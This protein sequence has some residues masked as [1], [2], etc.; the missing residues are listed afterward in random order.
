ML[1]RDVCTI[2]TLALRTVSVLLLH[3]VA[4]AARP[5]G[6]LHGAP[7]CRLG[8]PAG[9]A[10]ELADA[11][12]SPAHAVP[13]P[14]SRC[15]IHDRD[16]TS[17]IAMPRF[18]RDSIPSSR[19]RASRSFGPHTDTQRESDHTP[20]GRLVGTTFTP[21]P[22]P[23]GAMH[24]RAHVRGHGQHTARFLRSTCATRT[25]SRLTP[26]PDALNC[27]IAGSCSFPPHPQGARG[28]SCDTTGGPSLASERRVEGEGRAV[29]TR[30]ICPGLIA[31]RLVYPSAAKARGMRLAAAAWRTG[32]TEYRQLDAG[33]ATVR[34]VA[35]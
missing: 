6:R 22:V 10:A 3:R 18:P 15:H 8:D 33:R 20:R 28:A 17:T 7:G 5:F 13:Y 34:G 25:V 24:L 12:W 14:R 16:A 27:L 4:R 1:A 35:P 9:A 29:A 2:E 19:A 26:R 31:T 21:I 23:S 32:A 11:G 30:T